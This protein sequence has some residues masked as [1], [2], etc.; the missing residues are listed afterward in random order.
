MYTVKSKRKKERKKG[1]EEATT[2]TPGEHPSLSGASS[3]KFLPFSRQDYG[4][5][6]NRVCSVG[7]KVAIPFFETRVPL[8]LSWKKISRNA[9]SLGFRNSRPKNQ[10]ISPRRALYGMKPRRNPVTSCFHPSFERHSR[11]STSNLNSDLNPDMN[12]L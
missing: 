9:R 2:K 1:E 3:E 5:H 12:N 11:S 8:Q 6:E 7:F 10:R 4:T